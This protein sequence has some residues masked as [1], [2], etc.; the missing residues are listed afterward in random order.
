MARAPTAAG[1]LLLR[2][3][4]LLP[5]VSQVRLTIPQLTA[6]A[7]APWRESQAAVVVP[8]TGDHR[9]L[10]ACIRLSRVYALPQVYL[11]RG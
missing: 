10:Q 8:D 6:A 2:R 4:S 11:L 9:A 7:A 5:P 3:S 1:S